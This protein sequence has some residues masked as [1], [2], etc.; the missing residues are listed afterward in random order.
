MGLD[1]EKLKREIL[2]GFRALWGSEDWS[3]EEEAAAGDERALEQIHADLRELRTL[4]REIWE[5]QERAEAIRRKYRAEDEGRRF[6]DLWAEAEWRQALREIRRSFPEGP[7]EGGGL[8]APAARAERDRRDGT[9]PSEYTPEPPA[10][11][12]AD[13][14][15]ILDGIIRDSERIGTLSSDL[16][17]LYGGG[18]GIQ[19]LR[20]RVDEDPRMAQRSVEHLLLQDKTAQLAAVWREYKAI[21]ARYASPEYDRP[22][23]DPA[24]E[25]QREARLRIIRAPHENAEAF[26]ALEREAGEGIRA[27][28]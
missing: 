9:C 1:T 26:D 10:A 17:A 11:A 5:R 22:F 28:E 18:D 20:M 21:Q 7:D 3:G 19:R 8:R 27:E 15:R 12:P 13:E 24:M 2:S 4:R 6:A 16:L 14:A 25:A 23:G